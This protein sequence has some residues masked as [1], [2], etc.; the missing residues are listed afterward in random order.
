MLS[1]L[2]ETAQKTGTFVIVLMSFVRRA[3]WFEPDYLKIGMKC[4]PFRFWTFFFCPMRTTVRKIVDV[5][6]IFCFLFF[7]RSLP[8]Q[9]STSISPVRHRL[10]V[11]CRRWELYPCRSSP[12][13][14][15]SFRARC[16]KLSH[17]FF[18]STSAFAGSQIGFLCV[19]IFPFKCILKGV[20]S[21]KITP[22]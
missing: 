18:V 2:W 21:S 4:I 6:H 3:P 8:T 13:V 5:I 19:Y 15:T 10:K 20:L 11:S 14:P 9:V 17:P 16:T 1:P 22:F 12:N 7:C